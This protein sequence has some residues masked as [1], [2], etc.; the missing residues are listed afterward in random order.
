MLNIKGKHK[1]NHNVQPLSASNRRALKIILLFFGRLVF[2]IENRF[3]ICS[4]RKSV[5]SY[6]LIDILYSPKVFSSEY[7][8]LSNRDILF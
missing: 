5:I 8:I 4:H 1:I 3:F 7:M 6:R 2:A